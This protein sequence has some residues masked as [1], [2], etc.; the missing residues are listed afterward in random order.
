MNDVPSAWLYLIA[1]AIVIIGI[2]LV[3]NPPPWF[4]S[5][6]QAGRVTTSVV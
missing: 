1:A 3:V 2:G 4:E 6:K 5:S